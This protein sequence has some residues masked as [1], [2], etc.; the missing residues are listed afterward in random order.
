MQL[1]LGD[2]LPKEVQV[3]PR[4]EQLQNYGDDYF[5]AV[6]GLDD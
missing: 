3:L 6:C 4:P 1:V 5:P 2:P